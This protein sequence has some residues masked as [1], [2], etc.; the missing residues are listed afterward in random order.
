MKQAALV[1]T[2]QTLFGLKVLERLARPH[3]PIM[4]AG[5]GEQRTLRL[6][7][8]Y[9][10]ACNLFPTPEIPRKLEVLKGYCEAEG[11]DYA[12]LEKTSMYTFDAREVMLPSSRRSPA[13]TGWPAWASRRSALVS[14]TPTDCDRWRSSPNVS[15]RASPISDQTARRP[16]DSRWSGAEGTAPRAR[17]LARGAFQ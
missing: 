10:D 7:A 17:T 16:F 9:A 15:C 6:V 2:R 8:R 11:R 3:P 4:V 14:S 12:A 1:R 13:C 5:G